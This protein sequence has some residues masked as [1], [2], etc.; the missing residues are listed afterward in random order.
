M[1]IGCNGYIPRLGIEDNLIVFWIAY[2][3]Q[4]DKMLFVDFRYIEHKLIAW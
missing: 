1:A 3:F 4:R 2:N